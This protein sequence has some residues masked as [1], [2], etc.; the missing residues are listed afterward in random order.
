MGSG[1]AAHSCV[2]SSNAGAC[3]P[4]SSAKPQGADHHPPHMGTGASQRSPGPCMP[5]CERLK[6]AGPVAHGHLRPAAAQAEPF[7]ACL[8]RFG[9]R[10]STAASPTS[11]AH[12]AAPARACA[13]CGASPSQGRSSPHSSSGRLRLVR[14]C[15]TASPALATGPAGVTPLL[16]RLC[17]PQGAAA[18]LSTA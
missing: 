10:S 8:R 3:A 11:S 16:G 6:A 13:S 2:H 17:P 7:L 14:G 9:R 4:S 1:G 5:C 12:W 15:G 18:R